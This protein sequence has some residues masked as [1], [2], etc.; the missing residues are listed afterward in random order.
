M[1]QVQ[2]NEIN[3]T[4]R[5]IQNVNDFLEEFHIMTE[6]LKNMTKRDK[7]SES[8]LEVGL[9]KLLMIREQIRALL[10]NSKRKDNYSLLGTKKLLEQ[11][12]YFYKTVV[13]GDQTSTT[14]K[15]SLHEWVERS[16]HKL[17]DQHEIIKRE[18]EK[19]TRNSMNIEKERQDR[20][21]RLSENN[22]FHTFSLEQILLHLENDSIKLESLFFVRLNVE[23]YL[24]SWDEPKFDETNYY[25]IYE[26]INIIE[27]GTEEN[28]K[29]NQNST[30]INQTNINQTNINQ[31]N[32]NQTNNKA[33]LSDQKDQNSQN[34]GEQNQKKSTEETK[35]DQ[36]NLLNL[37]T[38]SMKF[39]PKKSK[40]RKYKPTNPIEVPEF[41]PSIPPNSI[42]DPK[43][44]LKFDS[45]TLFF[46]FYYLQGTYQQYL[47]A[48]K[49]RE[50][51]WRFHK[52]FK[53]W[54]RRCEEPK[55]ITSEYERG[56]YTFFDFDESW[57]EKK[58]TDYKLE[59]KYL[60]K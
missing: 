14:T 20:L 59:Y 22:K 12:I 51:G 25:Y 50:L 32:I 36:E 13:N 5:F 15:I 10:I 6:K 11:Q 49:L 18:Y 40:F 54:F 9:Q 26:D 37:L 47:A 46:I 3:T 23:N 16:L 34:V 43:T 48:Q 7:Q 4:E 58:K 45:H 21:F 41:F 53:T 44:F 2:Q 19:L 60:E 39:L 55:E 8:T 35:N 31:T 24:N 33:L 17:N 1:S 30:N 38:N 29:S 52:N 28:E 27:K 57:Q 42:D 56:S